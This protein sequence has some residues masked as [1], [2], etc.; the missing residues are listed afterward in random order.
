MQRLL[1]LAPP[2]QADLAWGGLGMTLCVAWLE[3]NAWVD[4]M[5]DR[6]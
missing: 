1:L 6:I 5:G 3:L 4:R 2:T